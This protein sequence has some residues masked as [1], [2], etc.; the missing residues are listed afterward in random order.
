MTN[1]MKS[2]EI[3]EPGYYWF[4]S[5]LQNPR[6]KWEVVQVALSYDKT[7]LVIWF[8]GWDIEDDIFGCDGYF[9]GPLPPPGEPLP[10]STILD[11]LA[12]AQEDR[13]K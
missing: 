1:T 13:H 5:P 10:E 3:K 7:R 8:T 12:C 9:I 2:S 4:I 11:E 6:A